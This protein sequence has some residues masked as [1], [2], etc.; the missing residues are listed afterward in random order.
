MAAVVGDGAEHL[1]AGAIRH[2]VVH[3]QRGVG[4]LAA[5]EQIDAVG[6]DPGA[7]AGKCDGRL[8]AA[9]GSARGHAKRVEVRMRAQRHHG[10]GNVEGL[11]AVLDQ[12]DMVE[13]RIVADRDDQR[14]VGLI[15]L[16]AIGCDVAFDQRHAGI[17]AEPQQRAGEHR[18]GRSTRWRHE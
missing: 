9:D 11:A 7:L 13:P 12:A 5:I 17:L 8:V 2:R 4:V 15:G 6:L 18:R 16:R 1:A 3:E 14:V 10:G